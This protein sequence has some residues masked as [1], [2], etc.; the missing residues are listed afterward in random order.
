MVPHRYWAKSMAK[1]ARLLV[2]RRCGHRGAELALADR[3]RQRGERGYI[4]ER[5]ITFRGDLVVR[6]R[7]E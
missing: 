7:W 3:R 5:H 2:C 4:G 1:L 6:R